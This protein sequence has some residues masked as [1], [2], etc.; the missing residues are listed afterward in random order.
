MNNYM[1]GEE[2]KR[3]LD[4]VLSENKVSEIVVSFKYDNSLTYV[5]E[6]NREH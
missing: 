1:S 3:F 4:A 2:F 5:H 6:S